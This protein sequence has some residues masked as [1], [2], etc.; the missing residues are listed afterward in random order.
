MGSEATENVNDVNYTEDAFKRRFLFSGTL[1]VAEFGSV[2]PLH[3]S[4][5]R[6][7]EE[8]RYNLKI[9]AD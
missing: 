4:F 2:A 8:M 9:E 3:K 6:C 1:H 7:L 5:V